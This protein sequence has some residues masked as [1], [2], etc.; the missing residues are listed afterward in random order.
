MCLQ[1]IKN[2]C[3]KN[4]CPKEHNVHNERNWH[5]KSKKKEN[6]KNNTIWKIQE[7][8]LHSL[9]LNKMFRYVKSRT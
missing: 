6:K 4:S 7:E 8:V 2:I 1:F 5:H 3:N 9:Y